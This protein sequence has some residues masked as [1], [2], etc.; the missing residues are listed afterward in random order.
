MRRFF[1]LWVA[2][3]LEVSPINSRGRQQVVRLARHGRMALSRVT[4][5]STCRGYVVRFSKIDDHTLLR[6]DILRGRCRG[7]ASLCTDQDIGAWLC[8]CVCS[9]QTRVW[10]GNRRYFFFFELATQ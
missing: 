5:G 1:W 4:D 2:P 7:S 6:W 8:V 10:R 9:P 3:S